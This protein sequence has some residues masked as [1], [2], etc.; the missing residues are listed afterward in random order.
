MKTIKLEY[1]RGKENSGEALK[2]IEIRKNTNGE[3][4][5][6]GDTYTERQKL[7]E[8]MRLDTPVSKS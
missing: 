2:C 4:I 7:G 8:Q 3:N 1:N 6:L 5:L